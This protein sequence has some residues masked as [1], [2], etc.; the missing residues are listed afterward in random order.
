MSQEARLESWEIW[1]N[2]L[3][4]KFRFFLPK[5]TTKQMKHICATIT[6]DYNKIIYKSKMW[7]FP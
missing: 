2:V 5:S 1:E 6:N 3:F 4:R 7:N